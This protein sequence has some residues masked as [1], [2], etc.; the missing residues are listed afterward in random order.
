[1]TVSKGKALTV[2]NRRTRTSLF[3]PIRWALAWAW[4][5]TWKRKKQQ[6]SH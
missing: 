4:R 5:S 2:S 6:I 1:M 3:W